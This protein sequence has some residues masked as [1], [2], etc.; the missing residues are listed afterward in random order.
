MFGRSLSGYAM[1]GKHITAVPAETKAMMTTAAM[2]AKTFSIAVR[3]E[4]ESVCL[5]K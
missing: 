5:F 4:N 2:P 1:L 3:S